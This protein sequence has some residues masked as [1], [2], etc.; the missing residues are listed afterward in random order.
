MYSQYK[1]K[2]RKKEAKK[3]RDIY[4]I[5]IPNGSLAIHPTSPRLRGTMKT[6]GSEITLVVT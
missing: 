4:K 3:E 2:E 6:F 1:L 5:L